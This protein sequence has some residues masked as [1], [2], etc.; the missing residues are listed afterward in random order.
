M[1][2]INAPSIKLYEIA[3]PDTGLWTIEVNSNGKHSIGITAN[4]LV[5]FTPS[6][7][8]ERD[9]EH[10][11]YLTIVGKPAPGTCKYIVHI[12]YHFVT[13]ELHIVLPRFLVI[14]FRRV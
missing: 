6:I 2:V 1:P 10:P 7:V 11:G 13:V 8:E 14:G 9:T 12:E 3:D 5:D 4:S